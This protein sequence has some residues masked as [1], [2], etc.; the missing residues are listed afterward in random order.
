MSTILKWAGNKTAIMA[1]LRAHLPEGQRLVE[2]F[3]GS[4]AVMMNTDYPAYLL[5]DINPDL[6]NF[7]RVVRDQCDWLIQVGRGLFAEPVSAETY[8]AI[9]EEFNVSQALTPPWRAAYFLYLNRYGYRG[10]CRYN[11]NGRFNVPYGNYRAPYFPEAELR[12]FAVKA[13]RALLVCASYAETLSMLQV[14][15]VVYCDPPYH[16]TFSQYHN[17]GFSEIDQ[18][19]LAGVLRRRVEQGYSVVVSNSDTP[20][21]RSLYRDFIC[22]T[23]MVGRRIGYWPDSVRQAREVIAVSQVP[24]WLG[25]D[26]G[27]WR[28]HDVP[29]LIWL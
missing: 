2:P 25:V 17:G 22:H 21:I 19:Q 26:W 12:A 10:L 11:R 13:Q 20:L 24:R 23:I 4:G 3:A 16:G 15:D 29:E 6:I 18:C 7:Y 1:Q 14:G 8:Y 5:A 9:R 27:R 28:D